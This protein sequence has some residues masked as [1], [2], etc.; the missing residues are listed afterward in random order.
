MQ[1]KKCIAFAVGAK[2]TK[3]VH[4]MLNS[5]FMNNLDMFFECYV[6][7]FDLPDREKKFYYRI[8]TQAGHSCR[9][10]Q[11][12]RIN[13]AVTEYAHVTSET[14]LRLL[15]PAVIPVGI[16]RVLYLDFDIIVNGSLKELFQYPFMGCSLLAVKAN[17][18]QRRLRD[19]KKINGVPNGKKYFNAGVL[20]MNLEMLRDDEHFKREFVLDYLENHL[21]EIREDDQGYLNHFLWNK[22]KIINYK[23]NYNAAIYYCN[24]YDLFSR[25][26]SILTLIK[27]EKKAE[28]EAIIIHFRGAS[29]PWDKKYNGQCSKLYFRYARDAGYYMNIRTHIAHKKAKFLN[30]VNLILK[31]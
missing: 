30:I 18:D 26:K 21:N 27:E 16:E 5:V 12:P 7:F 25:F 14:F 9:F 28:R 29:K 6:L 22:T 31:K 2:C 24:G 8:I 15:I 10:I 4:I 23:Y 20:V 1:E 3:Q 13:I 19:I 17:R 11:F